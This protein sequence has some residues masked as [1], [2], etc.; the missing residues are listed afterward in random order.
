MERSIGHSSV[1]APSH[2]LLLLLLAAAASAPPLAA[3]AGARVGVQTIFFLKKHTQFSFNF[4]L[5]VM[6]LAEAT[7]SGE[8]A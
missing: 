1:A 7:A 6:A 3:A 4:S 5:E 2:I 8:R